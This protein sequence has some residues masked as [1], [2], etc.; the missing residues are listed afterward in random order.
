MINTLPKSPSPEPSPT[1]TSQRS[2]V[3]RPTSNR[4]HSSSVWCSPSSSGTSEG[5]YANGCDTRTG[6]EGAAP[7]ACVF[8]TG[9]EGERESLGRTTC[10]RGSV[11]PASACAIS[12]R[13]AGVVVE[14]RRGSRTRM[15]CGLGGPAR[16]RSVPSD[17]SATRG[18]GETV[19]PVECSLTVAKTG[20]TSDGRRLGRMK[21]ACGATDRLLARFRLLSGEGD[22][23]SVA[24]LASRGCWIASV[25]SIGQQYTRRRK[26]C[27]ECVRTSCGSCFFFFYAHL[28]DAETCKSPN[29][30]AE[31]THVVVLHPFKDRLSRSHP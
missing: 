27:T 11:G 15:V 3:G 24:D 21:V 19:P 4:Q 1:A 2:S 5:G 7:F 31:T 9:E 8:T 22:G 16:E 25:R 10:R 13:D 23:G 18:G 17:A 28:D 29:I 12:K 14:C 6:V 26:P 30:D 20:A